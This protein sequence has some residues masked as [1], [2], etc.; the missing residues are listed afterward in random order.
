MGHKLETR[1]SMLVVLLSNFDNSI[2][3]YKIC[4]KSEKPVHVC[5]RIWTSIDKIR[6]ASAVVA[7]LSL[8][9]VDLFVRAS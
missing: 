7:G 3:A 6:G 4:R 8:Q 9:Q 1:M 5:E 2:R